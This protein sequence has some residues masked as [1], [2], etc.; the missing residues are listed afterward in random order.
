MDRDFKQRF[1]EVA[2]PHLDSV[3][4]LARSLSGNPAE[5]DDLVQETFV[6]AYRA[7]GS[8]E[9]RAHGARPWL[10]RILHNAFL[11]H[12]QRRQRDPLHASGSELGHVAAGVDLPSVDSESVDWDGFDEELKQAVAELPEEFRTVLMLLAIE[13]LS[14]REIA[15]VCECPVGTVMSRLHRARKGLTEKLREYAR[16]RNL[17]SRQSE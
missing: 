16:E 4:R 8:F 10:L 15:D 12:R 2:L 9:L 11:T 5:A 1:E 17:G 6:R 3:H 14:Y 7:F 13:G